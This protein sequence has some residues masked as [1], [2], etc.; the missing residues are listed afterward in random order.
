TTQAQQGRRRAQGH[1]PACFVLQRSWP[2]GNS[3]RDSALCALGRY[4]DAY[5]AY[6]NGLSHEASDAGLF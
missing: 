4:A 5:R 1:G 3:R 2:K 6:K